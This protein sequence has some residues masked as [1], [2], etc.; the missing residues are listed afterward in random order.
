MLCVVLLQFSDII[1]AMFIILLKYHCLI[2]NRYSYALTS[3]TKANYLKNLKSHDAL[4]Y[5]M[6]FMVY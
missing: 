4:F 1:Q 5:V 6:Y 2:V 3:M